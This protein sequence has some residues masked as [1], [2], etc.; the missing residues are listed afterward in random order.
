LLAELR[1]QKWADAGEGRVVV[2]DGIVHLWGVVGSEDE[3]K[4][5]RIAAENT[6]ACEASR[7]TWNLRL[8]CR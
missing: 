4:A 3:R 1:E 5:L 6:P 8:L 2:T 7:I